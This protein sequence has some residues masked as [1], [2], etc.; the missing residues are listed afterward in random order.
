MTT[1]DDGLEMCIVCGGEYDPADLDE[2]GICAQC[3]D[4]QEEDK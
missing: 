2:D 1:E 3:L 4:A